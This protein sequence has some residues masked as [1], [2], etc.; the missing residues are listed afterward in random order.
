M[1]V[2]LD[3]NRSKPIC[4]S[5]EI[6][7]TK[8][9]L[10]TELETRGV[11]QYETGTSES[12]GLS[13]LMTT[14]ATFVNNRSIMRGASQAWDPK[15]LLDGKFKQ[16]R[17]IGGEGVM[18][19]TKSGDRIFGFYLSLPNFYNKVRQMGGRPEVVDVHLDHPFFKNAEGVKLKDQS[20]NR[21]YSAA[22]IP[23]SS[24]MEELFRNPQ[25]FLEFCRR[26]NMEVVWEDTLQPFQP[27]SWY[28]WSSRKQNILLVHKSDMARIRQGQLENIT[29]EDNAEELSNFTFFEN[30]SCKSRAIV[31]DGN[32]EEVQTLFSQGDGTF[33]GLKIEQSSWNMIEF[34]GKV[35]M[36][37]NLDAV[38]VLSRADM[39]GVGSSPLFR[40]EETPIETDGLE[41][42]GGVVVLS[43]NQTNSFS[44]YSHEVL[45]FLFNGVNVLVY[46]NAGKGI[47]RGKNSEYSMT[48]ALRS[49]GDFLVKTKGFTEPQII[50]KGQCAGGLPTSEAGKMF[51]RSHVWV[52]QAPRTFSGTAEN[53]FLVKSEDFSKRQSTSLFGRV[54]S[55]AA[56]LLPIFSPVVRGVTSIAF[57]SYDVVENL[58]QNQGKH[59]YTIGV[60]DPKGH[61]GDQ[62]VPKSHVDAIRAQI[63]SEGDR[64]LFIGMPGATHVTDWW[65]DPS[66]LQRVK[67]AL[68]ETHISVDPYA[69]MMLGGR[70]IIEQK[71][72]AL[73][74]KP[75]DAETCSDLEYL[76]HDLIEDAYME[77]NTGV[78]DFNILDVR[79]EGGSEL[80][81]GVVNACIDAAEAGNQEKAL[82]HYL[83]HKRKY[84]TR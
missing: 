77:G 35:Y 63:L 74:G 50:F 48:E 32:L 58:Q 24:D 75:Y 14:V 47:S 25:E 19:N 13:A 7:H 39:R 11:V 16:Y 5:T 67:G 23:Y 27:A 31:F 1:C 44:S 34:N 78:F 45:T 76:V 4:G 83:N 53:M 52:D 22:R 29:A 79:E 62:L 65:I 15:R 9:E 82:L 28:Q 46:D 41:N 69:I 30:R 57:P 12:E 64:G 55:G 73:F 26:T 72:E 40:V 8:T 2:N 70:A 61:G 20:L 17:A 36:L 10:D 60:P 84:C 49:A 3:G 43:M 42:Q 59:I 80:E 21:E 71:Y 68:E 56:S 33:R 38:D 37:E 18:L 6:Q 81:L 51:P 66:V 54:I